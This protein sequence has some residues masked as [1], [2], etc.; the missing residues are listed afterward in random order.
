[1]YCCRFC[2]SSYANLQLWLLGYVHILRIRSGFSA[3]GLS[4]KNQISTN[5]GTPWKN[6]TFYSI[7][8]KKRIE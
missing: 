2:C 5:S 6:S 3:V 8:L 1:M 4:N 7:V